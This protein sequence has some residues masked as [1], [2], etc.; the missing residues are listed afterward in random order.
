MS[1]TRRTTLAATTPTTSRASNLSTGPLHVVILGSGTAIPRPSRAPSGILVSEAGTHLLLDG[2]A[3]TLTRLADAGVLLEELA[4]VLYTHLHVDHTGELVPLLFALKNP[5]FQRDRPLTIVGPPGLSRLHEDL[6]SVYGAWITAPPCGL[7]MGT[8]NPPAAYE[9]LGW[10]VDAVAVAHGASA[11]GVRLT[12]PSGAVIAYSGDTDECDA[13]VDLARD[14]DLLVLECSHPDDRKVD[15][16]LSPTPCGRVAAAARPR[17]L[18]LTHFYPGWDPED[19]RPPVEALYD[20]E[21]IIAADGLR[22]EV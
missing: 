9:L 5:G 15:G 7:V 11:H 13:V 12:S 8:W 14:A 16:H 2:G 20:G 3:G 4:A 6:A 22:I 17:R 10:R 21:V 19:A 1:S 18:V